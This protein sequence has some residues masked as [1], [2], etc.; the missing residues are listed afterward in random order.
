MERRHELNEILVG[1][2][3]TRQV[4]H[5][6]PPNVKMKYPCIVYNRDSTYRERADNMLYAKRARYKLTYISPSLKAEDTEL[7]EALEELQYCTFD[8]QMI[9]DSLYHTHLTI[10][11]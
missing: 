3:G 9:V 1:L 6:P 2:L 8:R 7:I 5:Q 11:Y 4:Y 10:Y